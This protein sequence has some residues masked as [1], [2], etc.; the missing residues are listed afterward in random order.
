ML[1]L[2]QS[3]RSLAPTSSSTI[4]DGLLLSF[5]P[6]GYRSVRAEVELSHRAA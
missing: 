3:I 1:N 6:T 4:T 2:E 5:G